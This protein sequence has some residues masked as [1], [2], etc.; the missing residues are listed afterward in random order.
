[1][2]KLIT[3]AGGII[4]SLLVIVVFKYPPEIITLVCFGSGLAIAGT[5]RETR[6]SQA[7]LLTLDILFMLLIIGVFSTSNSWPSES[8]GLFLT[9]LSISAITGGIESIL[10]SSKKIHPAVGLFFT[11]LFWA[12]IAVPVYFIVEN[13][14]G[15]IGGAVSIAVLLIIVIRDLQ[16]RK[17]EKFDL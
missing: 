16:R 14:L 9:F 17:K 4:L 11:V 2:L 5:L 12:P 7:T 10:F 6:V 3:T 15:T 8:I 1:L 13:K